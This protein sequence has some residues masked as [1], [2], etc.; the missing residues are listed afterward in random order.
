MPK[1]DVVTRDLHVRWY[2]FDPREHGD[3]KVHVRGYAFFA[4]QYY[5]NRSLVRFVWEHLR[6]GKELDLA[7]VSN[8]CEKLNGAWALIIEISEEKVIA[9]TDRFR[10]IPLFYARF[11]DRAVISVSIDDILMKMKSIATDDDSALEFLLS[12]SVTC[13]NTLFEGVR[14]VLPGEIIEIQYIDNDF[15][16]TPTRYYRFLPRNYSKLSEEDLERQLSSLIHSVF[17][18]FLK[19]T[20]G[21]T[22]LIPLSGGLD[23]RL[24]AAMLKKFGYEDVICYS[25]GR[26]KNPE[27]II[28]REVA[29]YL[30]YRWLFLETTPEIWTKAMASEEMIDYWDYGSKGTCLPHLQ[31]FPA[32]EKF[33]EDDE[34]GDNCVVWSGIAMDFLGG[35]LLGKTAQIQPFY[36]GMSLVEAYIL[37]R[38]YNLWPM[39]QT[40]KLYSQ[41]QMLRDRLLKCI[42]PCNELDRYEPLIKYEMYEVEHRIAYFLNNSMRLYEF[43]GLAWHLP[44]WDYEFVD[45]F[46]SVPLQFRFMKRLYL[47]TLRKYILANGMSELKRIPIYDRKLQFKVWDENINE[48]S[49]LNMLE[50][51]EIGFLDKLRV[52]FRNVLKRF[53]LVE[54]LYGKLKKRP[55][56]P[57]Q[58]HNNDWWFS[59]GKDPRKLDLIDVLRSNNCLKI[60]PEPLKDLLAPWM[61]TKLSERKCYSVFAVLMLSRI[62]EKY[63]GRI[64]KT[65]E[66]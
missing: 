56:T 18:R 19:A 3:F 15:T 47:N 46:L 64:S 48:S 27:A 42:D 14:Q 66:N 13:G 51:N 65:I 4:D 9:A 33:L 5:E 8:L 12:R 44:F 7:R 36:N 35:S 58:F 28:S 50:A 20:R 32:L 10:N 52:N 34:I 23:S 2:S 38:R 57:Q 41:T 63:D 11:E 25:Y 45:F 30:G 60:L 62:Y 54:K 6:T 1:I 43:H 61:H 24:V 59:C 53:T 37:W 49:A 29:G 31:E 21:K 17:Q 39:N 40:I 16:I 22:I 26:E 55:E